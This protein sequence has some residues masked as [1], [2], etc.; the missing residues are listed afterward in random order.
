MKKLELFNKILAIVEEET[1]VSR[2]DI[3]SGSKKE[4]VV[5]A[6]ALFIFVLHMMGFYPVQISSL[7]GICSR[8]INPFISKFNDRKDERRILR[9][10]YESVVK[11]LRDLGEKIP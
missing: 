3:L 2:E 4:E 5:D 1:E 8:C 9:I 6:R 10:N 11:Q 7:S